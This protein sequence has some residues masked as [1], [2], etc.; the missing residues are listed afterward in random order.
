[1][2]LWI[3]LLWCWYDMFLVVG[4]F[5]GVWRVCDEFRGAAGCWLG[6][7]LGVFLGV[8]VG[9]GSGWVGVLYGIYVSRGWFGMMVV[10]VNWVSGLV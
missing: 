3:G 8:W 6:C 1:M 5:V 7:F 2:D 4:M 9:L 10:L